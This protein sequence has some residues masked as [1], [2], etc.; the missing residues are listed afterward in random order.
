[1]LVGQFKKKSRI[2]KFLV[3]NSGAAT[4]QHPV[5]G[6]FENR[7][8]KF[9]A[10]DFCNGKSIV[11]LYQWDARNPNQP[12]WSQAFSTEPL[13]LGMELGDYIDKNQL[14]KSERQ[15]SDGTVI[16]NKKMNVRI[17]R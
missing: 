9:L 10:N 6:F 16:N 3:S 13:D 2:L 11:V 7:L 12:K 4:H 8:G 14:M 5:S 17:V 1:M 15:S